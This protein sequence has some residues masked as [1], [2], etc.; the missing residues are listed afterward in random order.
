[1]TA[2]PYPEHVRRAVA[3]TVARQI[4]VMKGWG[5]LN[6]QTQCAFLI[7]ADEILTALWEASRVDDPRETESLDYSA[8]ILDNHGDVH[9]GQY[10]LSWAELPAAVIYWGDAR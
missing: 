2:H 7:D 4:L 1:M 5:D 10:K 8:I 6:S 3:E 9:D